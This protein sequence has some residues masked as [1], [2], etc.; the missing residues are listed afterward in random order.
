MCRLEKEVTSLE[1][2]KRDLDNRI[3]ALDQI[4][5]S[6]NATIADLRHQSDKTNL[7]KVGLGVCH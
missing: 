1:E 4:I 7:E 5:E 3:V 6:L 2:V